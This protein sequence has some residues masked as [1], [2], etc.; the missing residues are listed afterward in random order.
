ME[1]SGEMTETVDELLDDV[2]KKVTDYLN[3]SPLNFRP[4]DL[5]LYF[6]DDNIV[7]EE[8]LDLTFPEF[9]KK[10]ATDEEKQDEMI[11]SLK[12]TLLLGSVYVDNLSIST[13]IGFCRDLM[14]IPEAL[15][16]YPG[17][18]KAPSTSF[19]HFFVKSFGE[20]SSTTRDE[21]IMDRLNKL[22]SE[23]VIDHLSGWRDEVSQYI[24]DLERFEGEFGMEL[25]SKQKERIHLYVERS[26]SLVN[27]IEQK[28]DTKKESAS[29]DE[30]V[31]LGFREAMLGSFS[32]LP[33]G[34]QESACRE[35]FE[36]TD[37]RV[38]TELGRHA[39]G[40]GTS[41]APSAKKRR[42]IEFSPF[43]RKS[44]SVPRSNSVSST[45]SYSKVRLESR[46]PSFSPGSSS[47]TKEEEEKTPSPRAEE[48]NIAPTTSPSSMKNHKEPSATSSISLSEKRVRKKSKL[49]GDDF[50]LGKIS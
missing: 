37:S 41:K 40:I 32:H 23:R 13:I 28:I 12:K 36:K 3:D 19:R 1:D 6:E 39:S 4:H 29:E 38:R 24:E 16:N 27:Q 45:N 11:D 48:Q 47:Y 21:D 14:S 15:A 30:Q 2:R 5:F 22:T 9:R 34:E 18:P 50:A 42:R 8:D 17:F 35:L 7:A 31:W 44:S 26:T 33:R 43:V 20:R 25:S 49:L 10:Y 46:E